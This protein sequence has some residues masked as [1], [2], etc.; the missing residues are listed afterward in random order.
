MYFSIGAIL[1]FNQISPSIFARK[2]CTIC[3]V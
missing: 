2:I 1:G 3:F